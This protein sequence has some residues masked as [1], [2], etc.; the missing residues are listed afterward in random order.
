MF[1]QVRS[2]PRG[3]SC[4]GTDCL[5]VHTLTCWRQGLVSAWRIAMTL[6]GKLVPTSLAALGNIEQQ[7]ALD[8]NGEE[9]TSGQ[10]QTD[11]IPWMVKFQVKIKT[12]GGS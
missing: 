1:S 8:H 11:E 5:E 10:P 2:S 3:R 7:D 12:G 6:A 9:R 4:P